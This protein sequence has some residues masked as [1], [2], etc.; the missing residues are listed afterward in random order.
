MDQ[1]LLASF[2][3]DN[4]T[5]NS[6]Y[7]KS[8]ARI[9]RQL[10]GSKNAFAA[11][12]AAAVAAAAAASQKS[13]QQQNHNNRISNRASQKSVTIVEPPKSVTIVEPPKSDKKSSKK[14]KKEKKEKKAKSEGKHRSSSHKSSKNKDQVVEKPNDS[15]KVM[16]VA[17][18]S[19][20]DSSISGSDTALTTTI[21]DLLD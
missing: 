14:E 2:L 4:T 17:D 15:P 11:T 16:P 18:R 13:A 12:A 5:Y 3:P 6:Q 20:S 19:P 9:S 8:P 1:V 7:G 10:H 21:E